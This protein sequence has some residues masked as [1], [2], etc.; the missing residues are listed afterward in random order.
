VAGTAFL[1]TAAHAGGGVFVEDI[2]LSG[3]ESDGLFGDASNTVIVVTVDDGGTGQV[4]VGFAWLLSFEAFDPSWGS[5]ARVDITSPEGTTVTIDDGDTGWAD[6]P[7]IFVAGDEITDFAGEAIA[8]DWTFRFYESFDDGIAPDGVYHTAF[9]TI[10]AVPAPA[11]L[12]LLGAAALVGRR[13]R[14]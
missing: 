8:G 10:K 11:G 2:N 4:V 7:G 12:A 9:F 13:R 1:A 6:D 5:E 3:A 14:R